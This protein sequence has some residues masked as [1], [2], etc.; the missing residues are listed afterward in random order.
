MTM[1]NLLMEI[2]YTIHQLKQTAEAFWK[3]AAEHADHRFSREYGFRKNYFHS[4]FM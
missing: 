4:R 2:T 1:L 3:I